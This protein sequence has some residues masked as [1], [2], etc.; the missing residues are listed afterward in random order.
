MNNKIQQI[1]TVSSPATVALISAFDKAIEE[2]AEGT[3]TPVEV[4]GA[5]E[6]TKMRFHFNNL[7]LSTLV[8]EQL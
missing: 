2:I 1:N 5:L 6:Y 7:A 4:I 8:D 3:L